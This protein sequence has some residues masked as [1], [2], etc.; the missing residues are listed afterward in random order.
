MKVKRSLVLL[1]TGLLV[2][3][4]TACE[5]SI[6]P[7]NRL[8]ASPTPSGAQAPG[9]GD[10]MGQLELFV[11]Q[12]ALAGQGQAV[13]PTPLVVTPE[14][15]GETPGEAPVE[16]PLTEAEP[17]VEPQPTEPAPVEPAPTEAP[18]VEGPT[19]IPVVVPTATPGIPSTY[20]VQ[21]GEHPF[22]L[23]RR[24]N[25]D[26][27]ELLR[28]NGLGTNSTVFPGTTLNIP[29]TGNP[30]PGTRA[31]RAH[32]T[33]HTVRAGDTINSIACEY[34]DVDPSAIA[35]ANSLSAPYQLSA[36]QT[37]QIP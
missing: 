27:G 37:I 23:A 2:L 9:D 21:G 7:S 28:A 24:F 22:C 30:F 5:R 25:V 16:T 20:T 32:P 1:I 17:P 26:P 4:L 18:P 14:A 29:Q 33:T 8:P 11:T 35:F 36:G 13:E 12:T 10:V 15:P 19:P 6:A 31:L 34:G 3:A